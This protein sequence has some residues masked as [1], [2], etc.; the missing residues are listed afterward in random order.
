MHPTAARLGRRFQNRRP[1]LSFRANKDYYKGNRQSALPGHR[2]GAPGVHINKRPG[3]QLL[4]SK[5]RVF[6]APPIEDILACPLKPYVASAAHVPRK[7]A[8]G[9]FRGMP[10]PGLTP[11][12]FLASAQRYTDQQLEKKKAEKNQQTLPAAAADA[13]SAVAPAS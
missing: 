10:G 8:N 9:I 7:E 3:Y 12:H 4:E 1:L 2:T 6:V 13:R 11:E 5:V